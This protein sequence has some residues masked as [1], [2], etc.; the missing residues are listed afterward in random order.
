[1]TRHPGNI[2]S[3]RLYVLDED[4]HEPHDASAS[5]RLTGEDLPLLQC[6]FVSVTEL[7]GTLSDMFHLQR[8]EGDDTHDW[9]IKNL[10]DDDTGVYMYEIVHRSNC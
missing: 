10:Q 9:I 3:H 7:V 4:E 8:T 5:Q 6:G 2:T 1:M